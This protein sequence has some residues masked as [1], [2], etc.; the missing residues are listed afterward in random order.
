[1]CETCERYRKI[2]ADDTPRSPEDGLAYNIWFLETIIPEWEKHRKECS[3]K[4]KEFAFT[5]TTN[6]NTELEVQKEMCDSVHKLFDQKTIPVEEGEAYLEYTEQGRPHIHGWYKTEDGGRIFA[7]VFRRCWSYWG[8]KDRQKKFAGGYHEEMK[9]NRY[10]GYA[11]GEGRLICRKTKDALE[12]YEDV[13]Y[14][15][16]I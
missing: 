16:H 7:K 4:Q 11:S 14:V 5:F 3:K 2:A 1:M 15:W 9:T 6:L 13:A 8:E 12:F 10:R